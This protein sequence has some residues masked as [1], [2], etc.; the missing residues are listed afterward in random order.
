MP[1]PVT[2]NSLEPQNALAPFERF[3]SERTCAAC[4]V[5]NWDGVR[6]AVFGEPLAAA[7]LPEPG[8]QAA[9]QWMSRALQASEFDYDGRLERWPADYYTLIWAARTRA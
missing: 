7:G 9:P 1:D 6:V 5:V 3:A 2:T 8:V 4:P